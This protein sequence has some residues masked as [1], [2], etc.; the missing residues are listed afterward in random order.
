MNIKDLQQGSYEVIS[1]DKPLNINNL[2]QGMATPIS[3][4][5]VRQGVDMAKR[6]LFQRARDFVV[7]NISGGGNVA[8]GLGGAIGSQKATQ[9]IEQSIDTQNK[10]MT[11]VINQIRQKR[12]SG[13][14]VSS[15][16]DTLTRQGQIVQ[17]TGQE[18]T[19]ITD[20]LP[21]NKEVIGSA[22][23]LASL[24]VGGAVQS[25]VASK[26]ASPVA[27]GIFSGMAGGA[28]DVAGF[29]VGDAIA[30]GEDP[31]KAGIKGLAM[32]TLAGGVIGTA[33]GT[34]AIARSLKTKLFPSVDIDKLAGRILQPAKG[35]TK[36]A[37]DIIKTLRDT[38][39]SNVKNFDDLADV[40]GAKKNLL[41]E[42]VDNILAQ[43]PNKYTLDNLAITQKTNTGQVATKYVDRAIE[44]LAKNYKA[45]GDD[46]ALS[47]VS[48][49]LS[50]VGAD[51]ISAKEVN[52]LAREY[53]RV[54][55]SRSFK[56]NGDLMNSIGATAWETN[57]KGIKDT[58][59][60]LMPDANL[61]ELDSE[62]S[63]L[64]TAEERFKQLNE[65][66]NVAK[67]KLQQLPLGGKLLSKAIEVMDT[68]SFGGVQGITS[69][70]R[71]QSGIAGKKF[72]DILQL[73]KMLE[74]NLG[75]LQEAME[76]ID[77]VPVERLNSLLETKLFKEI[78]DTDKAVNEMVDL[79][80]KEGNRGSLSID[81]L[82]KTAPEAKIY[83]D[84]L[85]DDL[86][87]KYNGS[88]AKASIKDKARAIQKVRDE[89]G[90]DVTKLRD[91][92]RNTVIVEPE[93]IQS[94]FDEIINSQ[95]VVSKGIANPSTDVM[96]YSG[97]NI[98]IQSPN[99]HIAEM[100]INSPDMIFAKEKASDAKA[101]LGEVKYNEL[102]DK[103][104][105]IGIRGGNGHVYYEQFRNLPFSEQ[106][107]GREHPIAKKSIAYYSNF[108]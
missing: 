55:S 18:A 62:I 7:D 11:D 52:D 47:N 61:K 44:D 71:K 10:G 23:Q 86:A 84:T 97:A 93:N 27:K 107:I 81:D 90:G 46:V 35:R 34:P 83:I 64:I 87:S 2:Q 67:N 63:K 92:A 37:T 58:A 40:T 96:G 65:L 49:M 42:Q 32:G 43:N 26:I 82:Y 5:V 48:D 36:Q 6:P 53:G 56:A 29:N 24:P 31:V 14:D 8:R 99:G 3:K 33:L 20:S 105:S 15:L 108:K 85:A 39:L 1:N 79:A 41:V 100:Q 66:A 50:R 17:Q 21:T 9:A 60:N 38:D 72:D 98:K 80:K 73:E 75:K 57:R 101:I 12:A 106:S 69:A 68:L 4:P 51:G 25:K 70:L 78:F 28:V 88:V 77:A 22:V 54:F 13:E 94:V 19:N 95:Q 103:Y 91:V 59:R 45:T 102:M 30:K 76:V 74:K 16:L 104:Q 89:Y